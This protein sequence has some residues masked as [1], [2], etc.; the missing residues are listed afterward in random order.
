MIRDDVVTPGAARL[1]EH[2]MGPLLE[3]ALEF[4]DRDQ[5]TAPTADDA[6]LVHDV[7][8]E[9]VDADTQGVGRL[10]L[11]QRETADRGI[12]TICTL[13]S[14]RLARRGHTDPWLDDATDPPT[15]FAA[16]SS[17]SSL[18][19]G[20]GTIDSPNR[21]LRAVL[22]GTDAAIPAAWSE[23]RKWL[24]CWDFTGS[25]R[26]GRDSNPRN[27]SPPLACAELAANQGSYARLVIVDL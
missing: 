3:P 21:R 17:H 27:E 8:L 10:G 5:P 4:A 1:L 16:H 12:R 13:I 7:L 15:T 19:D 25:E 22:R 18:W 24:V 11:G 20:C 2:L 26:R 14:N 6:Q 23:D 9:E